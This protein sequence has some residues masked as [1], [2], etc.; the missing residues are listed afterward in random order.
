MTQDPLLDRRTQT[1]PDLLEFLRTRYVEAMRREN[2]RLRNDDESVQIDIDEELQKIA[3]FCNF[4][5]DYLRQHRPAQL[6]H[7]EANFGVQLSN[8]ELFVIS[9]PLPDQRGSLQA[10]PAVMV[11]GSHYANEVVYGQDQTM[12]VLSGPVS[13]YEGSPAKDLTQPQGP[14]HY[15]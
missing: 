9:P 15:G 5:Q 4:G 8:Q 14:R 11:T 12:Q 3:C 2:D 1:I 6:F 13:H 7:P 10:S